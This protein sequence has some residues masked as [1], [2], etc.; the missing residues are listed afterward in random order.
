M[1]FH[2][3][4]IKSVQKISE[5]LFSFFE[6]IKE[7]LSVRSGLSGCSST[8]M[9]LNL[10]PLLAVNF[11]CFQEPKVLVLGPAARF[12]RR[13]PILLHVCIVIGC[14]LL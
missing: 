9:F 11:E 4:E 13:H 10:L 12:V 3:V 7:F 5:T 2:V 8:D 6:L 14:S 1:V